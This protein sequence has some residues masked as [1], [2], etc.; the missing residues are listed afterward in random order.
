VKGN[1]FTCHGEGSPDKQQHLKTV[2]VLE[3]HINKTFSY[4]QDMASVCESFEIVQLV[5]PA[6]LTKTE[7]D[8]DMGKKM[9]WERSMKNHMKRKDLMESNAIAICAIVWGQCSPMM[10]SKLESLEDFKE[11]NKS[12]DCV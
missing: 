10:Q 8:E 11:K 2:G 7:Y 5:Q 6:N 3:E 9:I 4:P 12:C 1:I